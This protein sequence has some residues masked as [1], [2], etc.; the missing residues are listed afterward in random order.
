MGHDVEGRPSLS[1]AIAERNRLLKEYK[2]Q[3]KYTS[4]APP[5][6]L[7]PTIILTS[8]AIR[9]I[10]VLPDTPFYFEKFLSDV[11]LALPDASGYFPLAVGMLSLASLELGRKFTRER[12][13]D[14]RE[15]RWAARRHAASKSPAKTTAKTRNTVAKLTQASDGK[16]EVTQTTPRA[17]GTP[18]KDSVM[19]KLAKEESDLAVDP[20]QN[21]VSK[22]LEGVGRGGAVLMIGVAMWSPGVCLLCLLP[23]A[24]LM[25]VTNLND[26]F[27]GYHPLLDDFVVLLNNA[28]VIGQVVRQ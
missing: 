2:C 13:G 25:K 9:N 5:L 1:K 12:M 20:S 3:P 6:T 18:R 27:S 10:C 8:L 17:P 16:W 14:L 24:A 15:S 28:N 23:S 26:M 21:R 11:P 4:L 22:V 19:E 7:L